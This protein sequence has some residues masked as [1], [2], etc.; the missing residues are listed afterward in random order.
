MLL[1]VS[2][3]LC[4][5]KVTWENIDIFIRRNGLKPKQ[6]SSEQCMCLGFLH[7]NTI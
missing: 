4:Q 3:D 1:N 2:D 6:A 7:C 5:Q